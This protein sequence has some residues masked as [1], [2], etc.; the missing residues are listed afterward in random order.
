MLVFLDHYLPGFRFGGIATAVAAMVERL[1]DQLE[2]FIVTAP[3]DEHSRET[4]PGI[5]VDGW[6]DIGKAQVFY[7]DH[8]SAPQL[9]RTFRDVQPDVVYLNSFWSPWTIRVLLLRKMGMLPPVPVVLAPRGT[10]HPEALRIKPGK[11]RGYRAFSDL[12][13]LSNNVLWHAASEPE[14]RDIERCQGAWA[15][16]VVAPDLSG[17][18]AAEDFRSRKIAGRLRAVAISRLAPM[19]NFEFLIAA[20]RDVEG[21]V[22]LD[23]YGPIDELPYWHLLQREIERL[24][25][26]VH[27]R[28]AG[29]VARSEVTAKLQEYDFHILPSRGENFGYSIVEALGAGVPVLISDQTPWHGLDAAGAGFDLP[30]VREQWTGYLQRMVGMEGAEHEEFR[31][32]AIAFYQSE[33]MKAENAAATVEMFQRAIAH[34]W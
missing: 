18:V 32:G 1:G 5:K 34:Q 3:R 15:K 11:K 23:L 27:V 2:F 33:V 30:L 25:T 31:R 13:R 7:T 4:Y 12:L 24:P 29:L 22:E 8:R 10:F 17:G 6:N 14:R 16:T 19:K 26:N 21:E 9:R 28:Y 20:L